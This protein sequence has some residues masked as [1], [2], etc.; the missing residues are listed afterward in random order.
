MECDVITHS[1]F[2]KYLEVVTTQL[3][4]THGSALTQGANDALKR[5]A[6]W[7][8]KVVLDHP[9]FRDRVLDT[10]SVDRCLRRLPVLRLSDLMV[11]GRRFEYPIAVDEA[12]AEQQLTELRERVLTML[13]SELARAKLRI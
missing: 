4:K 10:A 13:K 5:H 2:T 6:A 9:F 7:I 11:H 3:I 12:F 1:E 8:E